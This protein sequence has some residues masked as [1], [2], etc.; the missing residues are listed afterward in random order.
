[1]NDNWTVTNYTP[2]GLNQYT[3]VTGQTPTYDGNFHL[4][5]YG[6]WTYFHDADKRLTEA[7]G[8]GS[9][10]FIYD[11]LGRC[12]KRIINGEV[13]VL[14][15][16]G[17][18]PIA[19]YDGSGNFIAWNIYGPG[20]DEIL[21]RY[22]A[23]TG[24]LHYKLDALDNVQFLLNSSNDALER[25]TYDAFGTPR[26]TDWYGNV[27]AQG[28]TQS[29]YGNRFMFTGREYLSTLGIYDY[30]HRF[31]HPGLGRFLEVDPIGFKGDPMNLYRY[32][33]SNP[34]DRTDPDGL[35]PND[36]W[37]R[38]MFW[39]GDSPGTWN[40][41]F[42]AQR[43]LAAGTTFRGT[44]ERQRL[45]PVLGS[46]IPRWLTF[47]KIPITFTT[48]GNF[49]DANPMNHIVAAGLLGD[50]KGRTDASTAVKREGKGLSANL[51]ID[52]WIIAAR[53]N[54]LERQHTFGAEGS[55]T[56]GLL[57]KG[58]YWDQMKDRWKDGVKNFFPETRLRSGLNA[59]LSK[60]IDQQ[61]NTWDSDGGD[62]DVRW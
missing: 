39:Q 22:Q 17:W 44:L 30:R 40:E 19:E 14:V 10:Q 57:E 6:G 43:K 13:T 15:Y 18:K 24:Y 8:N 4:Y 27:R 61:Q 9:A 38:L 60:A 21:V 48:S 31:Y 50:L 32:C 5:E 58:G 33:G 45:V 12:V 36:A 35:I 7:S 53:Y 3:A 41:F 54:R 29:A 46:N 1:M 37:T 55:T 2:N 20:P 62:H 52:Y 28:P 23:N 16:D 49:S 11:G 34:V 42:D 51:R 59:E 47:A 26:I 56:K 25:Y